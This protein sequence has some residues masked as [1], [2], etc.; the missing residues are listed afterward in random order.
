MIGLALAMVAAGLVLVAFA[1]WRMTRHAEVGRVP[2]PDGVHMVCGCGAE[3][4]GGAWHPRFRYH[5]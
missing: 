2:R 3:H 5:S 4:Y 1:A